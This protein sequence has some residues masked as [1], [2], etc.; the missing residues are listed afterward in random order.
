MVPVPLRDLKVC[1]L[2]GGGASSQTSCLSLASLPR[3]QAHPT[4]GLAPCVA[5]EEA[6]LLELPA[7]FPRAGVTGHGCLQDLAGQELLWRDACQGWWVGGGRFTGEHWSGVQCR[8]DR[9][10][11]LR[12]LPQTGGGKGNGAHQ[13]FRFW[14]N[15]KIPA[16]PAHGLRQ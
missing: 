13:Q 6:W 10:R 3:S 12:R 9:W 14:R 4:A 7:L 2:T 1:G 16:P 11:D 15:L 8:Q 5:R